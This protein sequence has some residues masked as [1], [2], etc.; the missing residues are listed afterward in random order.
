MALVLYRTAVE[1]SLD[2]QPAFEF[3]VEVADGDACH[4]TAMND[5]R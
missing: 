1:D 5:Y 2:A 3:V 4:E